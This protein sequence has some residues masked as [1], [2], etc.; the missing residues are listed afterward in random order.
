MSQLGVQLVIGRLLTDESFRAHFE[1]RRHECLIGVRE[2]AVDLT[3]EEIAAFL[4]VD[5]RVWSLL[6]T[7]VD[8][9]LYGRSAPRTDVSSPIPRTLTSR[10]QRVLQRVSDGRTNKQIAV[11]LGV[12]ESSVKATLQQL[13]RKARVRTRTQ[14]VRI[15]LERSLAVVLGC[16]LAAAVPLHA[17]AQTSL[18]WPDVRSRFQAVNP[19]LV[20]GRIGVDE[21]RAGEVTA[22]LRPNPQWTM[23]F[24]QIGNTTEGN[25]FSA[26]TLGT[27]FS[28]LYERDGKRELRRDSAVGGTTVAA[29]T[30]ADLERTL[31]FTLRTSFVQVLLAKAF[32][33]LAKENLDNYDQVLRVS[34]SRFETGDLSRL[35]FDR[36]QLQRVAYESDVA[37]ADVNL[38]TAKIQL[39]RMLNDQTSVD[40]FDVDGPFDFAPLPLSLDDLHRTALDRRPDLR[41]AIEAIAKARTDERLAIANGSVDPTITVDAWFPSIS[42]TFESFSPPL[43]QYVGVGVA[44]PLRIFDRNQGEKLRT[45]LEVTRSERL[46]DAARV[47]VVSDVDTAFA[48]VTSTVT[49]LGPYRSS[50]LD[51]AARVRD[52]VTFAYEQGGASLLDFLQA[53]QEYRSVRLSYVNLV[54]AYLNAAAQLNLA[55]GDE[56][57]Q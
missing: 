36:L 35:D 56:V 2:Q 3:D 23:T 32:R 29:S 38:R 33:Q 45:S 30:Q 53:Q 21:A 13:F 19:A 54:A 42:Q 51:Q 46:A 12:S 15:A 57:V 27:S 44:M 8:R 47:Q 7:R 10:E 28:Y 16:V 4:D 50:Y 11:E 25:A 14:L 49:L 24:D 22:F 34:A 18:T 40:G 31:V 48:M 1:R 17:R 41:A 55:V 20:A 9:R 5:T 43:R 39:L 52:T 37:T 26:A 6:A